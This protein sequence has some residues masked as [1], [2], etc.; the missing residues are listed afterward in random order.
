MYTVFIS[1]LVFFCLVWLYCPFPPHSLTCLANF[2]CLCSPPCHPTLLLGP[3]RFSH[4]NPPFL[5]RCPTI[6]APP[7][8][9]R[10]TPVSSRA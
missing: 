2:M 3:S 10:P 5:S 6:P 7:L 8:W 1:A 9:S 4:P